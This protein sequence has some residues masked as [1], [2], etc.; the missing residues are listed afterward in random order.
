LAK[1]VISGTQ[2]NISVD[3]INKISNAPTHLIIASVQKL[4]EKSETQ[5]VSA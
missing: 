4:E 1:R 3:E 2:Y 5:Q